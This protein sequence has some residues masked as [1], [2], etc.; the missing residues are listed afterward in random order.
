MPLVS[1]KHFITHASSASFGTRVQKAVQLSVLA[2]GLLLGLGGASSYA[3]D[4][5]GEWVRPSGSS[6]IRISSC[7]SSLCGKIIWVRDPRNDVHNPDPTKRDK[8]LVGLLTVHSMKPTKKTDEWAGKVYNAEDG[9]TYKG[10]M[11]MPSPNKLK[12]EG[13]VLGGLICKGETWNRIK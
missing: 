8:S 4:P 1:D 7:G 5:A 6:K 3:A 2:T 12:L 11:T 9:K 10:V 13:C